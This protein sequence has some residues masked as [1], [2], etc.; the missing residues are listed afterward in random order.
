M[1]EYVYAD[2]NESAPVMVVRIKGVHVTMLQVTRVPCR[3]TGDFTIDRT[4][5]FVSISELPR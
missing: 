3:F 1:N 5:S 2:A 4:F